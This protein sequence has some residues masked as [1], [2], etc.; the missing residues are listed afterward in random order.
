MLAEVGTDKK[1]L[2]LICPAVGDDSPIFV[3][4]FLNLPHDCR[5]MRLSD[6][7]KFPIKAVN[8]IFALNILLYIDLRVQGIHA[9]PRSV[10][11]VETAICRIIPGDW[12]AGMISC[13][14][15]DKAEGKPFRHAV[16]GHQVIYEMADRVHHLINALKITVHKACFLAHVNK[17]RPEPHI[18]HHCKHRRSFVA[19]FC[20]ID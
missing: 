18:G 2:S 1:L 8:G 12:H 10:S 9:L 11:V 7:Q 14:V 4:V 3:I 13:P 19:V 17:R 15:L 6:P 5:F 20:R 16:S